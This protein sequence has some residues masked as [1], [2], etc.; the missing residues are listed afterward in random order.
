MKYA[1]QT[2]EHLERLDQALSG[3][4][5]QIKRGDNAAALASLEDGEIKENFENLRDIILL[6]STNPALG[7]SGVPNTGNL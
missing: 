5:V 2:Q 1:R 3:L 7:A 6:S 4:Y